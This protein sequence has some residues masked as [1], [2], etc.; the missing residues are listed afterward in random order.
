MFAFEDSISSHAKHIGWKQSAQCIGIKTL[1]GVLVYVVAVY[2]N[3]LCMA[4]AAAAD[5]VVCWAGVVA[6]RVS[7]GCL[8]HPWHP[9]VGELQAP[10]TPSCLLAP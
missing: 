8:Y 3:G 7:D 1:A 5:R 9:L 2:L 4:C 6:A 10:K